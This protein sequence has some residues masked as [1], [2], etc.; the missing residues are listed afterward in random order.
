M[1]LLE[2]LYDQLILRAKPEQRAAIHALKAE[3]KANLITSVQHIGSWTLPEIAKR[4][5]EY[6]AA[7]DAMRSAMRQRI[8]KEAAVIYPLLA[9]I[10]A[11]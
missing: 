7:S 11:A 3:G 4:W 1:L 10:P 9:D 2:R 5:P 6:C 8:G